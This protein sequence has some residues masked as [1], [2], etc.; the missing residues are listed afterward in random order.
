[1]PLVAL[2]VAGG[3]YLWTKKPWKK[4]GKPASA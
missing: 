3:Y 2:I 4:S 1:V